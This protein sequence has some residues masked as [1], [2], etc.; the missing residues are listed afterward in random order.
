M[1]AAAAPAAAAGS[2][3]FQRFL[4]LTVGFYRLIRPRAVREEQEIQP[5]VQENMT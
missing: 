5:A 2:S 4:L 3:W 1:S